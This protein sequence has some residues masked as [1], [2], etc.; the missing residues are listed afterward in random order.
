[1]TSIGLK[2]HP[3]SFT[4][5]CAYSPQSIIRLLPLYLV[6]KDV[7]FLLGK[8]IMPQ[9]PTRH[10]SNILSFLVSVSFREILVSRCFL[11]IAHIF[12]C[13]NNS[14]SVLFPQESEKKLS[15]YHNNPHI[16]QNHGF[17]RLFLK[18]TPT[19]H[20]QENTPSGNPLYCCSYCFPQQ[21][22]K[23]SK[24]CGFVCSVYFDIFCPTCERFFGV[25][26][27]FY[28]KFLF[29]IPVGSH[30]NLEKDSRLLSFTHHNP[31]FFGIKNS[32]GFPIPKPCL[33]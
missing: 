6:I 30:Y 21:L 17:P 12:F 33:L 31:I 32:S 8:G 15:I 18:N 23:I 1:M 22:Q 4:A 7:N 5:T 25:A 3:F 10:T 14:F 13:Y 9:L 27:R 11:F 26:K 16:N 2:L 28:A 20:D 24:E 19:V 29:K